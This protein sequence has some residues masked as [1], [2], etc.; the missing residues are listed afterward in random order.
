[1]EITI[2]VIAVAVVLAL[3]L[4]Y[5]VPYVVGKMARA[6]QKYRDALIREEIESARAWLE[7]QRQPP[8]G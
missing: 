3:G 8:H 6:A 2:L 5:A 4:R 7:R 1:M